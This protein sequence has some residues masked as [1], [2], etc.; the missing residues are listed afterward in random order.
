MNIT[1]EKTVK[2]RC[3][4]SHSIVNNYYE[5]LFVTQDINFQLV[6]E[7]IRQRENGEGAGAIIGGRQ[8]FKILLSK[9]VIIRGTAII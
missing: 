3:F 6:R 2:N 1:I 4:C 9:G 7:R 8:F 5:S